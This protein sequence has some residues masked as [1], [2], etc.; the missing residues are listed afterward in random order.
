MKKW[1][2]G[3]SFLGL[4][5]CGEGKGTVT[6]TTYG[7]DYI[8]KQIPA[9][10]NGGAGFVDGWTVKYD[11]FLVMLGE[12]TV[13]THEETAAT[14]GKSKVFD[15][16]KPGP[17]VVE[18][19]TD[20][21]AKEWDHVSYAIAP[22]AEAEAGNADAQD[23]AMM[24][25]GGYS[26]YVEGTATKGTVTKHFA[27]GFPTN[28]VYEH[29]ENPDLGEGV[30]VPD[31][32]EEKVE[33]TLHGDHLFFDDLQ[34]PRAKLRF[35]ALADADKLGIVGADG[36]ITLEEL[37]AVDL[38]ELPADQYGTGGVGN[39]HNLRDF[40]TALVRTVGHYRGEGEC[41]P[42]AR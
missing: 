27:W 32:G 18:T 39:V 22:F 37:A 11:K 23:V 24:K 1:L 3:L 28:T 6:F 30:T 14:Q 38:T 2:L 34:S 5:A 29:C 9:S 31:G 25:T 16:H 41:S 7:E 33:L 12:V 19:F 10:T 36:E 15:V 21:P 8:E 13:A 40:V 35:Q 20:L 26:V 4:T 17:V 42:R